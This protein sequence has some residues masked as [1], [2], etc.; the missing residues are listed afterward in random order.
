MEIVGFSRG[1]LTGRLERA[2]FSAG[3][4]MVERR[5]GVKRVSLVLTH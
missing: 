1:F 2:P 5:A 3:A 4:M